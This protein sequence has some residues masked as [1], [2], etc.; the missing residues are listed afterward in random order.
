MCFK[1]IEKKAYPVEAPKK[2]EKKVKN[3]GTRYPGA[4]KASEAEAEE[5]KDVKD[6]TKEDVGKSASEAMGK[7]SVNN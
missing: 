7:L 1:Q 2:K 5:G 3:K 6:V 4:P